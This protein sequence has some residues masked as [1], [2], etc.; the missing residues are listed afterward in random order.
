MGS[1]AQTSFAQ[2]VFPSSPRQ[3][4]VPGSGLTPPLTPGTSKQTPKRPQTISFALCDSPVGLLACIVDAIDPPLQATTSTRPNPTSNSPPTALQQSPWT[5]TALINWVMLYWLPGPEVALRWLNNSAPML[6][7]LWIT[8]SNVPLA[9]SQFG[10]RTDP[11]VPALLEM[12]H[13][14]A[15]V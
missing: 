12:H 14:I 11:Q 5:P 10:E 8:H 3:L 13:R 9:I 2:P 7:N 6:P 1:R 4:Q 15:M